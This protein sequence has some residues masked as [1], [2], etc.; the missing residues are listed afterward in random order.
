[1]AQVV[2]LDVETTGKGGYGNHQI[3][4]VAGIIY[5]TEFDEFIGEFE[6]LVRPSRSIDAG[7]TEKHGLTAS[8][9]SMAPTFEEVGP[10]LARILHRRPVIAYNVDFDVDMLNS[11]FQRHQIDFQIIQ[12]SCAYAP[13][14]AVMNLEQAAAK[15]G[16]ELSNWHS[17]LE[18]ARAAFAISAYH[19]WERMLEKAGRSEHLSNVRV[20]SVRTLSR[21]QAGLVDNYDLRPLNRLAEFRDYSP[22]EGYLLLLDE[23]LNDKD[24][25][26]QELTK[27]E[28]YGEQHGLEL[29]IRHELHRT[30]FGAIEAAAKRGGVTE[31]EYKL[32]NEYAELLDVEV[33]VEVTEQVVLLPSPG[34]LI[35]QTGDCIIDG[36][37]LS[38][39]EV[40]TI[41]ESRGY[42]FTDKMLK[43]D[44]VD[45]LLIA[46][47]GHE[48]QKTRKAADWGIPTL[49]F[50]RFLELS[51]A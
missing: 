13:F 3:V 35:C 33:N 40:Q 27:L 30:Y 45:L 18:D 37:T 14:G 46:V 10:M 22:E 32:L 47:E 36:R 34:A 6:T 39:S 49:T 26:P 42:R 9:L 2:V 38:K 44:E 19:G 16:Y 7:A 1:M 15:V 43:S 4:E 5:E 29:G 8:D 21:Y 51:K 12:K 17:A 24:I 31:L 28:Q 50:T 25:T 48:S 23:V 20:R 11:E 41:V